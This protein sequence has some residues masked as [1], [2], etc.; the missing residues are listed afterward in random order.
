MELVAGETLAR[1]L[2]HGALPV[3]QALSMAR[4][5]ADAL[6]AAHEKGVVHRDVKPGNVMLMA[7]GRVKVLDFGLAKAIEDEQRAELSNSPTILG[8]T[9]DGVILGTAAYMS[10]EQAKGQRTHPRSDIWAFGCVLFEMLTGTP[11]FPGETTVEILAGIMKADPDWSALPTGTPSSIRVLLRR[12]TQRDQA[13][14]LH[15]IVDARLEIDD[16]LREP[17][18]RSP[19]A[20]ASRRWERRAWLAGVGVLSAALLFV[21]LTPRSSA[22]RGA[23]RIE[24]GFDTRQSLNSQT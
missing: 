22:D 3:E 5:I 4:Q 17:D 1:R 2:V 14:R 9:Q 6:A 7:G 12:C 19:T 11:A 13:R 8:A 21:S 16:A 15:H 24:F 10:P 20:G 18:T 23:G